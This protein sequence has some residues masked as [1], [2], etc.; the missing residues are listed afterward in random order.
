MS[1]NVDNVGQ[2][3]SHLLIYVLKKN[4]GQVLA[5]NQREIARAVHAQAR[6]NGMGMQ[7]IFWYVLER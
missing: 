6:V 1:C 4:A 3:V 2:V 7:L 5:L